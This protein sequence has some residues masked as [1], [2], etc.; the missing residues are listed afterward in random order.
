MS[1]TLV[2]YQNTTQCHNPEDLDLTLHCHE[3]NLARYCWHIAYE[4]RSCT[5]SFQ[6]YR[7]VIRLG[8]S[9]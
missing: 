9:L 5:S 6:N 4:Y 7:H 8:H 3:K 2:Y 1:E